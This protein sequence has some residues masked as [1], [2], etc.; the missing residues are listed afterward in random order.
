MSATLIE[1]E[2]EVIKNWFMKLESRYYP[3]NNRH[4]V[5]IQESQTSITF[6]DDSHKRINDIN[7][8]VLL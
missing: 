1:S 4:T 3:G 8:N 7:L 2:K 6:L 5:T